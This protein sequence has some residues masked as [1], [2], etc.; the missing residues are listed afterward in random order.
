MFASEWAASITLVSFARIIIATESITIGLLFVDNIPEHEVNIG[1]RTSASAVL[2]A[3]DRIQAENLLPGYKIDFTHR[4][5]QCDEQLAAGIIVDMIHTKK[6]DALI[7]PTCNR[8]ALVASVLCA[9]YNIP[10]FTWGLTTAS[11]LD[12]IQRFPTTAKLSSNS[13]SLGIALRSILLSFGWNQFGFLYSAEHNNEKCISI[14]NDLQKA[15]SMTNGMTINYIGEFVR[16]NEES[17][18]IKL[19][20]MAARARIVVVCVPEGRGMRRKLLLTIHDGGYLTD[21]FVYIFADTKSKGF[22]RPL[23][24]GK[25]HNYWVDTN[26]PGD[27]RDKE[28]LEAFK[29]VFTLSDH[30]GAGLTGSNNNN[31]SEEVIARMKEPPLECVSECQGEKY[32]AASQFASQLHDA[33]YV[34]ARAL[35]RTLT[36]N[37]TNLRNGREILKNIV[38]TFDGQSGQVTMG[39]DGTRLPTFFL[40]SLNEKGEQILRGTVSVDGH[41][42]T[43]KPTYTDEKELWFTRNGHRPRAKPLCGFE[44]KQC[45]TQSYAGWI[46]AASVITF[47]AIIGCIVGIF[48][49]VEL[50]RR[51]QKRLNQ[52]WQIQYAKLEM[53]QAQTKEELILNTQSHHVG[54]ITDLREE[55]RNFRFFLY[56][57]EP[58]AA[59]KHLGRVRL[60]SKYCHEMRKL[61][62][63]E[64]DNLNRFVGVCLDGPQPLSVWK[65]CRRGSLNDVIMQANVN[66]DAFFILSLLKDVAQGL[67]FIHNSYLSYHGNLTSKCCLVDDRWQVKVSDYGL[68]KMLFVEKRSLDDL[69]WTAPEILRNPDMKGTPAGD[70]YSFAII[71]AQ[72]LTRSSVFGLGD[73]EEDAE[74][75]IYMLKRGGSQPVRPDLI[76]KHV[77]VHPNLIRLIQDCWS[78]KVDARPCAN[79]LDSYLKEMTGNKD[80]NLMDHVFNMMESHASTLETEVEQ[81]MKDLVEEKKKSDKLLYRMQVAEKLKLGE[82]VVPETFDSVT[83]FFSDVVSFTKIA[84]RGTPLQVVNLLNCLYTVFDS[85]I[86]KHDVYKV[87]TIGDGYLCVSGLPRRNG[88]E[89]AKEISIMSLEFM[90]SLVNFKIPHLPQERIN[91]RIGVH[92]GPVVAGVVGLTMPRYCLFGDTVN[93]ASRMES[94]GKPG[95]IH[96]SCDA[97]KV[98]EEL[99][100]FETEPRGEVI[101]K[102]KGVMETYWLKGRKISGNEISQNLRPSTLTEDQKS[103][104]ITT[105]A[106]NNSET[107]LG[108]YKEFVRCE[109]QN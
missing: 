93:T 85:I 58:V 61:R 63:I 82:P 35:N 98:L 80:K 41:Y 71:S 4:F 89:H 24:G 37:K 27:G 44:G 47:I 36:K 79:D 52:L 51:E 102:G 33:V 38:M 9:H 68:Q 75:L 74:D 95:F 83:V 90:D 50:K 97:N 1:Y 108:I 26:I 66:M 64:H 16:F 23:P 5:D 101:I 54:L 109:K 3:R 10:V 96:L 94:N 73:R 86:D 67:L 92:S 48:L 28:A 100:G 81:R 70:I 43:Y 25:V 55:S 76:S 34:Y 42:G 59:R 103:P 39:K 19:K 29:R 46:I 88:K 91:L 53:P 17:I 13:F 69:L 30:A 15:I 32:S 2:I 105:S 87:E 49:S 57:G 14:K 12:D 78:E 20:K 45:P 65:Y 106:E 6:I 7:G 72:L 107:R 11:E 31:F 99:G 22:S 18:L 40:D 8:P 56:E 62:R 60:E 84:G 104:L 77:E 21:E